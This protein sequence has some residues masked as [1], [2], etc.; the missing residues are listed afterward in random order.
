[1][2]FTTIIRKPLITEKYTQTADEHNRYAFEV[3]HRASKDQIR[4]AV[5]SIY[6]VRVVDVSTLNRKGKRRRHRFG[7]TQKP[8]VKRAVVKVH[9][10]DRIEL[11]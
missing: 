1:M 3:D 9:P 4:Q 8:T 10:D 6:K 11:F 7:V 2:E 5:E